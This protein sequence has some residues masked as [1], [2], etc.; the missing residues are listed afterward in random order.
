MKQN[1]HDSLRGRDLSFLTQ[2]RFT[3]KIIACK[4]N[5]KID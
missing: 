4:S 5:T 3:A 1:L 2:A